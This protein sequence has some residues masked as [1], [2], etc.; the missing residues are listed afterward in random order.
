MDLLTVSNQLKASSLLA[1]ILGPS[2]SGNSY[3]AGSGLFP[4]SVPTYGK[5]WQL[6]KQFELLG[7]SLRDNFDICQVC[8]HNVVPT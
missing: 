3:G 2:P 6:R 8:H 7:L 4:I 5:A 1:L